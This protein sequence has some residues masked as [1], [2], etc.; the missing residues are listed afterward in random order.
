[1]FFLENKGDPPWFCIVDSWKQVYIHHLSFYIGEVLEGLNISLDIFY[2]FLKIGKRI[3]NFYPRVLKFVEQFVRIIFYK[4]LFIL[5]YTINHNIS[6]NLLNKNIL[7]SHNNWQD[8][9]DFW[10][11]GIGK[12]TVDFFL[13]ESVLSV[14]FP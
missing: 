12:I 4:L 11:N 14:S 2:M 6:T 10:I 8:Y 1:M 9:I 3:S 7:V 5:A 13:I